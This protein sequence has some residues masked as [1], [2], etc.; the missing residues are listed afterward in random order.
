M[1]GVPLM[2]DMH[3][4]F[5]TTAL[6]IT[7]G[8]A[9]WLQAPV[10]G[11]STGGE[12]S[13]A[14][15]V[16]DPCL[17]QPPPP[18]CAP[19]PTPDPRKGVAL[20]ATIRRE[21]LDEQV[22]DLRGPNRGLYPNAKPNIEI[23]R[24]GRAGWVRLFVDW[25]SLQPEQDFS[26]DNVHLDERT[27]PFIES[28]DAQVVFARQNNLKVVLAVHHRFPLWSN[29]TPDP[30]CSFRCEAQTDPVNKAECERLCGMINDPNAARLKLKRPRSP[31]GRVPADLDVDSPWGRWIDF[32]V[33]RYGYSAETRDA[34]RYVDYL[35]VVNEPN[36]TMWPQWR[37][38][39]VG[40]RDDIRGRLVIANNVALMF[41]T[42]QEIVARRNGEA[43]VL[44]AEHAT[45]VKLAGPAASDVLDPKPAAPGDSAERKEKKKRLRAVRTGYE[46]FTRELLVQLGRERFNPKS[47]FSFS[48]HDYADVERARR[49]APTFDPKARTLADPTGSTNSAAW[50]RELLRVGTG[51]GRANRWTG[52]PDAEHP[53]LL[54]TESGARL[55]EVGDEDSQADLVGRNFE[56]LL[57]DGGRL[58]AGIGLSLQYLTYSDICF[59]TGLFFFIEPQ[60]TKPR[61]IRCAAEHGFTGGGG[62]PRKVYERWARL[63]S[64]PRNPVP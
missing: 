2:T 4:A 7:L 11:Q 12:V 52:W 54:I 46:T 10:A 56:L 44:D 19:P 42:A 58:R 53:G 40:N 26:L 38:D 15:V 50:V 37:D 41:K 64:T 5:L 23:V 55:S 39:R 43:N 8:L 35:E 51:A 20:A 27:R 34:R 61:D 57:S 18:Q 21:E 63:K 45:T 16:F 28:L 1:K 9:T 36:L 6:L 32:L 22:Q 62:E 25:P 30:G 14:G 48:H 33:R 49:A 3:R 24:E 13:P 60:P 47:Y 29:G 31:F 17:I 59:D